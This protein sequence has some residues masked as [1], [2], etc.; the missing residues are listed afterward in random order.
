V[1]NI[2]IPT[3]E[4]NRDLP[5]CQAKLANILCSLKKHFGPV[6]NWDCEHLDDICHFRYGLFE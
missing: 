4:V 6:K 5:G 2:T 1:R 3:I